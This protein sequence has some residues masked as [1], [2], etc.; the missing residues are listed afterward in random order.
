MDWDTPFTFTLLGDKKEYT[1]H[2]HTAAGG[3]GYKLHVYSILLMVKGIKPA[4]PY[5]WW[6]KGIHRAHP[7]FWLWK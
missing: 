3:K 7:Y 2:I 1:L 4:S 5:C 6:L